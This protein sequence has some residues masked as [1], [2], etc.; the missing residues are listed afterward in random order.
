MSLFFGKIKTFTK[1]ATKI[2]Q[3]YYPEILG[4]MFIVNS[5]FMFRGIWGIVSVW[6]DKKTQKKIRIISGSGKK[7]LLKDIDSE[8]LPEFLGGT[9]TISLRES[10]GPW[11]EEILK[12]YGRKSVHV[13]DQSIVRKYY[14]TPQ[15]NEE[16]EAKQNEVKSSPA[17]LAE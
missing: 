16:W 7:D 2:A 3:D 14:R 5:G 8:K 6:I 10:P 4:K 17:D 1:I 11:K 9:C 15:E 12:S 13:E